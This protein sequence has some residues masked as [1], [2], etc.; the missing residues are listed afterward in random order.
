MRRRWRVCV[1]AEDRGRKGAVFITRERVLPWNQPIVDRGIRVAT[2][3]LTQP[4]AEQLIAEARA[5][6]LSLARQMGE[7]ER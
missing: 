5:A 2:L 4:N 1:A 7:L 3:S 6:A